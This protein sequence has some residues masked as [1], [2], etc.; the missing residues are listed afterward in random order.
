MCECH[1]VT[2]DTEKQPPCASCA[3]L[4]YPPTPT[5]TPHTPPTHRRTLSQRHLYILLAALVLVTAA[6]AGGAYAIHQHVSHRKLQDATTSIIADSTASPSDTVSAT[7]SVAGADESGYHESGW[8]SG[9][10]SSPNSGV[11]FAEVGEEG[12]ETKLERNVPG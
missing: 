2:P 1:Q 9:A 3:S 6:L 7:S 10:G 5:S 11:W 12:E 8:N 4:S